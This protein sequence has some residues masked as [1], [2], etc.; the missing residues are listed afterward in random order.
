M[1]QSTTTLI[2]RPPFLQRFMGGPFLRVNEW[3][4]NRLP[5][6][7]KAAPPIRYYGTLMHSLVGLRADRNQYHGT[8]FLRNRPE[9]E[10]IQALANRRPQGATLRIAIVACSNGAEVYSF[11]W[12]IRS[13][14]PDLKLVIHA[15]DISGEI[16]KIAQQGVYVRERDSLVDAP[17]FERLTE[18][19]TAAMFDQ[20]GDQ[21]RIKDWLREDIHWHVGDAGDPKLAQC[22]GPQDILVANRF[23]CH[24]RP[25]DAEDCL[26]KIVR[27]V[28]PGGYLFVSGVDLDVR[29]MVARDLGWTPVPEMLEE[30]HNGDSSVRNDWPWRYWGLE[31]F[32]AKRH[33]ATLR[34]ASVFQINKKT[35]E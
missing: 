28:A 14:R 24:M 9:L 22:L 21:F 19:E 11:A 4:W 32:N 13:A 20:A 6:S 34:Y 8:F 29:T 12:A 16:V 3:V 35:S 31:P 17:I 7:L 10:L 1:S 26:R 25:P 27:L 2:S 15:V 18:Q 5:S 33:D 23:L 30:V